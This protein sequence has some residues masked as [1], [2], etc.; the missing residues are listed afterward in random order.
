MKCLLAIFTI[1]SITVFAQ[2]PQFFHYQAVARDAQG[3]VLAGRY[4][5][6]KASILKGSPAGPAMYVE[7]HNQGSDPFGFVNLSIGNG[8]VVSGNFENIAWDS[9]LFFLQLEMDPQGGSNW[10]TM[11]AMQLQSV[12]YALY[13]DRSGGDRDWNV[14]GQEMFSA[15]SGFVGIGTENPL[16]RMTVVGHIRSAFDHT[17][18]DFLEIY[19]GPSNGVVNFGGVGHLDFRYEENTL[20]RLFQDG[21]MALGSD[22]WCAGSSL[23]QLNSATQGFRPP[24]MN[25]DKIAALE[26]PKDGLM[27]F[28]TTDEHLYIYREY[29]GSK[30]HRVAL[31]PTTLDPWICGDDLIDPRD[32]K[33]YATVEI[34][35]QCWMAENINIGV[36]VYYGNQ[37]DNG[38]IEKW[39]YE[40]QAAN[41]SLYGGLYTWDEAMQY[42]NNPGSQGICPPN[43]GWHIP[44]DEEWKQLE[45]AADSQYGYPDPEWN[46]TGWRGFDA[47]KNLKSSTAWN[48]LDLFGFSALPAGYR[49]QYGSNGMGDLTD[50]WTSDENDTNTA[51]DRYLYS[52]QDE[53]YRLARDKQFGFSVRCVK[54]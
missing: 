18:A 53:V 48:G 30:W 45:G 11:G 27:V 16:Q 38:L 25:S 28:N 52:D 10:F 2:C 49:T 15:T 5:T 35:N 44:T 17:E 22:T 42:T 13:A 20:G 43:G 4:L 41:C 32:N 23:L 37:E 36:P 46:M 31:D 14:N 3:N 50:W 54:N 6:F 8:T 9:D 47:G 26:N 24:R 40:L 29:H 21:R 12:P 34:G 7:T 19:H 1:L 39:C 51:L 33:S